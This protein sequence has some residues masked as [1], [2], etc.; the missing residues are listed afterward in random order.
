MSLLIPHSIHAASPNE[1][2]FF[3]DSV[4]TSSLCPHT[5]DWVYFLHVTLHQ[6]LCQLLGFSMH[7][8]A[9]NEEFMI[10][11]GGRDASVPFCIE[12]LVNYL[13]GL[14]R[15]QSRSMRQLEARKA[16]QTFSAE[17]ESVADNIVR[18]IP[19][20][21]RIGVPN[22]GS[23]L[24]LGTWNPAVWFALRGN[25]PSQTSSPTDPRCNLAKTTGGDHCSNSMT[26]APETG[27]V[28]MRSTVANVLATR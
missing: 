7:A 16:K 2:M 11:Y 22:V 12:G 26:T 23:D 5:K 4:S 25:T 28:M 6:E 1:L 15:S 14:P 9:R 20:P 10:K 18:R 3:L 17:W 24:T 27:K 21:I 13:E 8:I 19:L